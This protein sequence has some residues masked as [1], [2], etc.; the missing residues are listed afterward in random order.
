MGKKSLKFLYLLPFLTLNFPRLKKNLDIIK[1]YEKPTRFTQGLIYFKGMLIE[2]SGLYGKS[3]II[4]YHI[5]NINKYTK[6]LNFPNNIFAEGIVKID[7]YLFLLTWKENIAYKIDYKNL[8]IKGTLNNFNE[9]FD[10]K[11]GW[12]I[13]YNYD[14]NIIIVSDGSSKLYLL[15]P[16]TFELIGKLETNCKGLNELEYGNKFIVANVWYKNFILFINPINGKIEKKIYLPFAKQT[17]KY[18]VL[19]GIAYDKYNDVWYFTGKNWNRLYKVKF[20][21]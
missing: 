7:D 21:F 4:I 6:K 13:T 15:N 12:G 19:N 2:S 10:R 16:L 20:N 11:E 18:G 14:K 5:K 3:H 1:I 8:K 17:N 9:L